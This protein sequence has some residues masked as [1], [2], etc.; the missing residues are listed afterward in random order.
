[1]KNGHLG[2]KRLGSAHIN[3]FRGIRIIVDHDCRDSPFQL[4]I[5]DFFGK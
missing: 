3:K 4:C 5:Q 2:G 1:M